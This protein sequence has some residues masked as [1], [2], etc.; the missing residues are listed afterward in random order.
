MP[1]RHELSRQAARQVAASGSLT[2]TGAA[3]H[4]ATPIQQ[5]RTQN[6]SH[7]LR[8]WVGAPFIPGQMFTRNLHA[9]DW[10]RRRT[11]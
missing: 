6:F 10:R 5:R 7:L 9:P 1:P 8:I 3:L 2:L 11:P 4:F